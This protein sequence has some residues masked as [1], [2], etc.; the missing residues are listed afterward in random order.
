MASILTG[1]LGG[2]G[3]YG[4]LMHIALRYYCKTV[5]LKD[6]AVFDEIRCGK[7]KN[8]R[9]AKWLSSVHYESVK[10]QKW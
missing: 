7:A 6:I 2:G 4:N 9:C 10:T 5:R 8:C 3:G 1:E